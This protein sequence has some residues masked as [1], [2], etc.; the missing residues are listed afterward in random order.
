MMATER[1][2]SAVPPPATR[3]VRRTYPFGEME[4][5]QSFTEYPVQGEG[6]GELRRKV[7]AASRSFLTRS[8]LGWIFDARIDEEEGLVRLWRVE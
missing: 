7:L 5:G 3:R 8:K 1:L 6:L 4:V 2:T